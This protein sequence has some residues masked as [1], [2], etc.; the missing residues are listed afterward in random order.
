MTLT[1]GKSGKTVWTWFLTMLAAVAIVFENLEL[2]LAGDRSFL[3][4]LSARI[5]A[6]QRERIDEVLRIIGLSEQR[7]AP[8]R[9]LA[10]GQKQWLESGCC[11]CKIRN[12]CWW[13]SR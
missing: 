6:P 13:M 10:H 7:E 4:M 5:S 2:A 9:I 11:S 1:I 12:C 3:K 8:G